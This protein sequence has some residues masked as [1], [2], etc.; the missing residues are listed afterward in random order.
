MTAPRRA[1]QCRTTNQWWWFRCFSCLMRATRASYTCAMTHPNPTS[2]E[3]SMREALQRMRAYSSMNVPFSFGYV[4]F[5]AQLNTGGEF[6]VVRRA[7]L[8]PGLREDQSDLHNILIAYTD[9]QNEG[10]RHFYMPLLMMFNG[11]R[12]KPWK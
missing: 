3:I 11:K 7:L 5:S 10:P 1:N 4:S 9:L 6:K 8:R 2:T 12:V